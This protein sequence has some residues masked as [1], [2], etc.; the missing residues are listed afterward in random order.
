VCSSDLATV[1]QDAYKITLTGLDNVDIIRTADYLAY[2][3]NARQGAYAEITLED[4]KEYMPVWYAE[5][6]DKLPSA[7][8]DGKI[9]C[10]PNA[11]PWWNSPC[12]ILRKDWFPPGMTEVNSLD[13]LGDYFAYVLETQPNI[14][15]WA[16]STGEVSWINGAYAFAA[17][18]LMAPG[19]PNCTSVICFNKLDDPNYKLLPT[20]S[21]RSSSRSSKR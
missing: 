13:D 4:I 20:C 18:N 6:A 11:N 12:G 5:N 17:S 21:S 14:M 8:V 7:T 19:G 1:E 9:Y 2:Y 16:M 10:I 15:P 3:D